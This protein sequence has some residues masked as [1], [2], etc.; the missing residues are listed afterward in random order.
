MC[1]YKWHCY[2]PIIREY[3]GSSEY[4]PPKAAVVKRIRFSPNGRSQV[5]ERFFLEL[6]FQI[7]SSKAQS[8]RGFDFKVLGH[9]LTFYKILRFPGNIGNKLRF[10]VF[11]FTSGGGWKHLQGILKFCKTK[12]KFVKTGNLL[13]FS[14]GFTVK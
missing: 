4:T 6:G 8:Q 14:S 9:I 7:P 2:N 11:H 5:W 12:S 13:I 3:D 10:G 1:T